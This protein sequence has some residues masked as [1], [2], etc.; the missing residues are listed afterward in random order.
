MS[1]WTPQTICCVMLVATVCSI[2]VAAECGIVLRSDSGDVSESRALLNDKLTLIIGLVG[3]FLIR[4]K[5]DEQHP[6]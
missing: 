2:L 3:G 1:R 5:V 4:R 6:E